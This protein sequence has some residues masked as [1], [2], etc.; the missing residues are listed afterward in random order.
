M[1]VEEI[2]SCGEV[3]DGVY[4]GLQRLVYY[5]V[6]PFGEKV[7]LTAASLF[8]TINGAATGTLAYKHSEN[9]VERLARVCPKFVAFSSPHLDVVSLQ[10]LNNKL[11]AIESYVTENPWHTVFFVFAA[12]VGVYLV[13]RRIFADSDDAREGGYLRKGDRLD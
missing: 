6:D 1:D 2:D 12:I 4:L 13:L 3:A 9:V 7:S 8:P 11:M 5:D 10:Y